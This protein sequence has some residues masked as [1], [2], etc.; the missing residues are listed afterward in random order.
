MLSTIFGATGDTVNLAGG[1]KDFWET[2]SGTLGGITTL[3][4]VVGMLIVVFAVVK[5][6]WDKRKSGGGGGGG[7][8]GSNIGYAI[9]I[10]AILS[11]PGLI[12]PN[13]L[14]IIDLLANALAKIISKNAS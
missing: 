11:A 2:I 8:S 14:T 4:N 12:I 10:G 9:L 5:M 1:W 6:L 7:G 3:M 13:I